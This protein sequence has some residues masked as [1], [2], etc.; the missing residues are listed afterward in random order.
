M[1]PALERSDRPVQSRG[2]SFTGVQISPEYSLIRLPEG[3]QQSS[4][5]LVSRLGA[6]EVQQPSLLLALTLVLQVAGLQVSPPD[7]A[8]VFLSM[9][10]GL[11]HLSTPEEFPSQLARL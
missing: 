2:A 1:P 8:A 7:T 3:L 10:A 4:A 5:Q 6:G 9:A 11:Q